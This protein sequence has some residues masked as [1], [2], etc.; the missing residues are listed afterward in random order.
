MIS[1]SIL[2]VALSLQTVAAL[3]QATTPPA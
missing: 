1:R 3:A 2:V